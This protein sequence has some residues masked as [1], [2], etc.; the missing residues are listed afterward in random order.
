M[1][2]AACT[3]AAADESDTVAWHTR[4]ESAWQTSC[5]EGRPLLLFV[6]RDDCRFCTQMKDRTFGTPAVARSINRSFVALVLDGRGG[7]PLLRELGV[8]LY[9]STFIISPKAIVLARFEG[10]VAPQQFA[11]VLARIRPASGVANREP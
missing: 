7:E 4:V 8:K 9:P 2:I 11:G 3:P 10:F 6:T 5:A 1:L